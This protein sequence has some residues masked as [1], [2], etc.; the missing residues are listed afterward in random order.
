MVLNSTNKAL[1]YYDT[2]FD[3]FGPLSFFLNCI[4]DWINARFEFYVE[5]NI[6]SQISKLPLRSFTLLL[7]RLLKRFS[8]KRPGLVPK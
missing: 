7:D 5:T 8:P 2:P 4:T 1:L 6:Q 3:I